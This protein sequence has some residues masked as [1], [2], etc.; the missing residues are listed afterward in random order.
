MS[1][2]LVVGTSYRYM[3]QFERGVYLKEVS[4]KGKLTA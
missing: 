2:L 3:Y 1:K 4:V